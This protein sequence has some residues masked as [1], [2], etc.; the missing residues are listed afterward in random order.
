MNIT[1]NTH[2]KEK[3]TN[4][5]KYHLSLPA[6][7]VDEVS[8]DAAHL[9]HLLSL[10]DFFETSVLNDR[11]LR[12]IAT[13][14]HINRD[15][16]KQAYR[17]WNQYSERVNPANLS[18]SSQEKKQAEGIKAFKEK[19]SDLIGDLEHDLPFNQ[20]NQNEYRSVLADLLTLFSISQ[21]SQQK[22]YQTQS[23]GV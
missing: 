7:L 2:K 22:I 20:V 6:Y 8:A 16:A 12:E 15:Q 11:P 9:E 3:N 14:I 1:Q 13:L 5:Q 19:L 18:L 17:R 10:K 21:E 23:E 4:S